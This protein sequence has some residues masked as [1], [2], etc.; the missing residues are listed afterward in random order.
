MS[1]FN[2]AADSPPK[3]FFRDS[4]EDV[5]HSAKDVALLIV[6]LQKLIMPELAKKFLEGAAISYADRREAGISVFPETPMEKARDM[7]GWV[8]FHEPEAR[9][10][11]EQKQMWLDLGIRDPLCQA[12]LAKV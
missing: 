1:E 11:K 4:C 7:I 5:G 6:G 9:I 10:S 12:T 3:K 2:Q 8:L